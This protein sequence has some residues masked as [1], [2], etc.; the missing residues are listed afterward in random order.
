MKLSRSIQTFKLSKG[1]ISSVITMA[2]CIK[3]K[4]PGLY[5][6]NVLV[7]KREQVNDTAEAI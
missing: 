6:R 4:L 2:N 1:H 7:T 3:L 5:E